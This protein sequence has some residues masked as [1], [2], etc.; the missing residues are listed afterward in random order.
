M[1]RSRLASSAVF[2][3]AAMFPATAR[4]DWSFGVYGGGCTTRDSSLSIAQP[5][6]GTNVILTPVAYRS[7]SLEWPVYYGYRAGVFPAAGAFGIE[8]EFIHMKV[9]ADTARVVTANG[10]IRGQPASGPRPLS[11]IVGRFAITHGVNLVLVNAVARLAPSRGSRANRWT[12]VGRA[13][14]G[15]SVPHAESTIDGSAVDRYE[16][17]AFSMQGS[18]AVEIRMHRCLHLSSEYKLTRTV[19]DV[20]I[21]RGSARTTLVTHHLAI[22]VTVRR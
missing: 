19:Q 21:A 2:A 13:G 14:A 7:T 9:T 11:S 15:A 22:G 12:V 20:S 10:T 16:W 4:A 3:I 6:D 5:A 1:H 17:G 8:G 18:A